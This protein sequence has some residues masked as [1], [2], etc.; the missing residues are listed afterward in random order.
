MRNQNLF[1]S[2]F[3]ISNKRH[4]LSLVA[5]KLPFTF[6]NA[7]LKELDMFWGFLFFAMLAFGLIKLGAL[8]VS[9]GIL[10]GALK[11]AVFVAIVLCVLLLRLVKR[12]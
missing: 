9:V 12:D 11:L 4:I 7:F 8:S 5:C 1:Q 6:H 10:A 2:K 3:E